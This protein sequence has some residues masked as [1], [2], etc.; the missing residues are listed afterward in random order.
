MSQQNTFI[1]RAS[2]NSIEFIDKIQL[3]LRGNE[4]QTF[5]EIGTRN[6]NELGLANIICGDLF[7]NL[8]NGQSFS[9][10]C[11]KT[12]FL[13]K[14]MEHFIESNN[15]AIENLD[16]KIERY[17]HLQELDNAEIQHIDDKLSGYTDEMESNN[18]TFEMKF[19]MINS[20]LNEQ[21]ESV[22]YVSSEIYKK[23]DNMKIE[24]KQALVCTE[25]KLKNDVSGILKANAN[26]TNNILSSL[27]TH[28]ADLDFALEE[29][30]IKFLEQKCNIIE[31]NERI[32]A[33]QVEI[34]NLQ[35]HCKKTIW[36]FDDEEF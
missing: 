19:D 3:R 35:E 15:E 12:H 33:D 2:N 26:E 18:D 7:C 13:E 10:L 36:C 21:A 27:L 4:T 5:L 34:K 28:V 29:L 6:E 24:C 14:E 1:A 31:L 16:S 22:E 20:Q 11:T 8:S 32:E 25:I 30:K 9:T 17:I 23:F